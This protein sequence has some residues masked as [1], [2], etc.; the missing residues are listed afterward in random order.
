MACTRFFYCICFSFHRIVY[1]CVVYVYTIVL[2]YVLLRLFKFKR[3][4][5]MERLR[6]FSGV[7]CFVYG[8]RAAIVEPLHLL[9]HLLSWVVTL[10]ARPGGCGDGLRV[11][12]ETS[13]SY[14]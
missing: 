12:Q 7:L 11:G 3:E 10:S 2:S 5:K 8:V 6:A 14:L 4:G 1:F 13:C 9:P